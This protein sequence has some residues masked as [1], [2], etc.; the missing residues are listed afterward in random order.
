MTGILMIITAV[1]LII[2]G[3]SLIK[4]MSMLLQM[5]KK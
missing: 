5:N 4:K 1:T 2:I 3:K